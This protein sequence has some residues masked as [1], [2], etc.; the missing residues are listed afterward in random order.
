MFFTKS[1]VPVIL[2]AFSVFR[3]CY[4]LFDVPENAPDFL[5]AL[6][7]K[8][9]SLSVLTVFTKAELIAIANSFQC[10]I[11]FLESRKKKV[12]REFYLLGQKFAEY[13]SKHLASE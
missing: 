3:K 8:L 5:D 7:V 10:S 4:F 6:E 2:S 11:L 9:K 13:F 1:D 12:P